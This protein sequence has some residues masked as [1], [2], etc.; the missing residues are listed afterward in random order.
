MDEKLVVVGKPVPVSVCAVRVSPIGGYLVRRRYAVTVAVGVLRVL[1]ID[2]PPREGCDVRRELRHDITDSVR[3][4]S[5][6]DVG[7][8]GGGEAPE[9]VAEYDVA[10]LEELG[11]EADGA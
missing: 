8:D 10:V 9:V 11:L 5:D 3:R 6:D 1:R 2:A 4:D 7:D